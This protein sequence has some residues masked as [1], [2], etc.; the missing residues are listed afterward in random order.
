MPPNSDNVPLIAIYYFGSM[1]IISLA[2]AGTVLS[3]NILKK[4]DQGVPVGKIVQIIFFDFFARILFIKIKFNKNL[5][6]DLDEETKRKLSTHDSAYFSSIKQLKPSTSDSLTPSNMVG[7]QLE[8][9]RAPGLNVFLS[10][11]KMSK[12]SSSHSILLKSSLQQQQQQ[13]HIT[14]GKVR[15]Q[16]NNRLCS[17]DNSLSGADATLET[18]LVLRPAGDDNRLSIEQRR[19]L[20]Y[21]RHLNGNLER[22]HAKEII[23]DYKQDIKNQWKALAK[24]IDLIMLYSFVIS[25]IGM[26]VFLIAQVPYKIVMN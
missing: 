7:R 5:K 14:H 23:D 22:M 6:L 16:P 21:M 18:G 4:G 8:I 12:S 13:Q 2:T 26:F 11:S 9:K 10:A 24:V 19:L 1:L 15:F 25:T 3:L 20:K 17:L